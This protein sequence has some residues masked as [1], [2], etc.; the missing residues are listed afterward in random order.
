[1]VGG[2]S[3][4]KQPNQAQYPHGDD[5]TL[6]ATASAG[7]TFTGWS[8]DAGGSANP[9]VVT[10]DGPKNITATFT[11]NQ[12]TLDVTV[13]GS[14]GVTKQPDRAQYLHGDEVTL[15]AACRYRLGLHPLERRRGRQRQPAGRHHGRR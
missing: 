3:V 11:Q 15:T 12:Y 13:V 5:V 1:M 6:T 4:S 8:G 14:G 9:L 7:W 2:G 10:M